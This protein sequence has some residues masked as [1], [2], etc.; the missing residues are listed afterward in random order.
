[1]TPGSIEGIA[2][3]MSFP[4]RS[5][6]HA[7]VTESVVTELQKNKITIDEIIME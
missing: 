3:Y 2:L 4:A 6:A 1:M 7:T 5:E